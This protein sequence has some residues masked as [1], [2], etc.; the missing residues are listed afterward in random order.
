M[1]MSAITFDIAGSSQQYGIDLQTTGP[2]QTHRF[3]AR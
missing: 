1:V 3:S 2:M